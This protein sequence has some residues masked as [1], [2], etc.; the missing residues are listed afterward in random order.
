MILNAR[1][2]DGILTARAA[3]HLI[4]VN[5]ECRG[6][7]SWPAKRR[8]CEETAKEIERAV[9]EI[10]G[11]VFVNAVVI[12]T[13]SRRILDEGTRTLPEKETLSGGRLLLQGEN[14]SG[15]F[16]GVAVGYLR[17][18]RHMPWPASMGALSYLGAQNRDRP[19]VVPVPGGDVGVRR[20][21]FGFIV[22]VADIA[23]VLLQQDLRSLGSG[24]AHGGHGGG[25]TQPKQFHTVSVGVIQWQR[26]SSAD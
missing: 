9:R 16:L 13:R 3:R 17:M 5:L 25:Q 26:L 22:R 18:G 1:Q 14:V 20:A 21:R 24:T 19:R 10:S 7:C 2:H 15:H 23:L 11:R 8:Y 4:G 12:L 6:P